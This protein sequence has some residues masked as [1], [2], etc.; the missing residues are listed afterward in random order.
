MITD[1]LKKIRENLDLSQRQIANKLNISK[2]AYGRWE[3]GEYIIPLERLIDF[4]KFANCSIDYILELSE[5]KKFKP[6][7]INRKK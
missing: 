3:S 2:T 4:C 5:D 6:L 1:K 7:N